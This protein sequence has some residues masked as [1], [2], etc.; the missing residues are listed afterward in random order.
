MTNTAIRRNKMICRSLILFIVFF[1][2]FTCPS[3][4][5]GTVP[6]CYCLPLINWFIL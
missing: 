1:S 3:D 2:S 4:C 6:L 5:N